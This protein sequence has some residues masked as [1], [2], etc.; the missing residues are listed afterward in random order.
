VESLGLLISRLY[1]PG[2]NRFHGR[3]D[4]K[5]KVANVHVMWEQAAGDHWPA[6][7]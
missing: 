2:V 7:E 5:V 3:D 4:Y 6:C 1:V